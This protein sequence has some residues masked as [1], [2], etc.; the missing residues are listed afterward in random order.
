M[1][2][3]FLHRLRK[4]KDQAEFNQFMDERR[5]GGPAA[6]Q[7]PEPEPYGGPSPMPAT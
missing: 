1:G 2:E 3:E 5:R 7:Q 6:P 4:A